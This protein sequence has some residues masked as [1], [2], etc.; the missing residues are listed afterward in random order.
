MVLGDLNVTP[1]SPFF[2]DLLREG[3]LR[4]ARKGYGL[5]PTWPTMLPP[6]LIPVDHCLVSSG[7]TVHDCRAG[8][9]V[10][11]DHYPLVVDFSLRPR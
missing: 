10:G 7:V 9:N 3:A 11:S 5:R 1:W 4:N 2:R 6:L 8:R